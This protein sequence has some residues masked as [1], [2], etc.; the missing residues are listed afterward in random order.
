MQP[1]ETPD[2]FY[3]SAAQ[4]WLELGNAAEAR[5]ELEHISAASQEHPRVLQLRWMLSANAE[6]WPAALETARALLR[7]AP[8][9]PEAWLHHAYALRRAPGGGLQA[10]WEALSP[11]LE[12][13]TAEATIPYNLA[14][15]ACQ[16][17]Q[18]EAA[19]VLC[20]RAL[21]TAG[22]RED[23]K[24]MALRDPDLQPLWPEIRGW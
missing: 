16:L 15:Y 10:A 24:T 8:E 9:F 4:G 18:L 6:D 1:L 22:D 7:V 12:K 5:A 2:S 20:R 21:A 3:V 11:A 17:G 23:M 19:R 13:F 14:C